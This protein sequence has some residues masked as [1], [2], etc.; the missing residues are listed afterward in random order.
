MTDI[1]WCYTHDQPSNDHDMMASCRYGPTT[2]DGSPMPHPAE[3]TMDLLVAEQR[4]LFPEIGEFA[5][6]LKPQMF[7][8]L[9]ALFTCLALM[10]ASFWLGRVT[11]SEPEPTVYVITSTTSGPV[12]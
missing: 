4:A 9:L 12:P 6:D 11:T 7:V 3:P 10:G 5:F 8:T 1:P 2:A